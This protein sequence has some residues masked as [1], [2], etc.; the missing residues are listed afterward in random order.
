MLDMEQE[1][2]QINIRVDQ[3]LLDAIDDIRRMKRPVPSKTDVI[4]AAVLEYRDRLRTK[5]ER[6]DAGQ[7]RPRR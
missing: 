4:R 7:R 3:D 1:R 5:M 2:I 6:Q